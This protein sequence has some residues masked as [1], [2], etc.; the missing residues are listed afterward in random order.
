[1]KIT[2]SYIHI[3]PYISTAWNEVRAVWK[4]N[5]A[6]FL[7]LF[8]KQAIK[9][10]GLSEEQEEM[11]F[12]FH[13]KHLVASQESRIPQ[14]SKELSLPAHFLGGMAPLGMQLGIAGQ[15]GVHNILQ[16]NLTMANFPDL[17]LELLQRIAKVASALSQGME[18]MEV[19]EDE[20]HCNC[21]HCQLA[22]VMRESAQSC[23]EPPSESKEEEEVFVSDWRIQNKE[24]D[25]YEVAHRLHLE[26]AYLVHLGDPLGCTCGKSGCEHL[27]AVLRS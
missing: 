4:E 3:P 11:I 17:P 1:M 13:G 19:S 25:V 27:L 21:P 18:G 23:E 22:R 9:I 5:D 8:G 6:V 26:E 10:S 24:K 15:G 20:P 12:S 7:L 16:H 2:E 14:L